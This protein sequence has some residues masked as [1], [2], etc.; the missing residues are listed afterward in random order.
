LGSGVE[1]KQYL[2]G[3]SDDGWATY[4]AGRRY[5]DAVRRNQLI[6]NPELIPDKLERVRALV[7]LGYG[8]PHY[9]TEALVEGILGS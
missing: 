5:H 2:K 8:T 3:L 6:E 1:R 7:R 4:V 9:E